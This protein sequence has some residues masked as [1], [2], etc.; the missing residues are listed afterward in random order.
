MIFMDH[1]QELRSALLRILI[2]LG[3]A[4]MFCYFFGEQLSE[5]L[6]KP[7]RTVMGEGG[8]IQGKIIYLSVLDK[9]LAHFQLAFWSSIILASPLWFYQVWRFIEPGLYPREK[10]VIA[11]FILVGFLLFA[12][13]VIF[14]Y[15]MALP[16]ALGALMNF[17]VTN[18]EAT[19][20][21]RGHLSLM[22]KVLVML[23]FLFQL[24]NILLVLGL[25]GLV[26]KQS[27][28]KWRGYVYFALAVLSA[29]LTPADIFT[30]LGLWVP[31]VALY[32]VGIGVVAL[33]VHP[34]LARKHTEGKES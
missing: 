17:G 32:E 8:A 27:L 6:L 22:V 26:T 1:L 18:V 33:L 14:G 2:I 3:A 11:P 19:I 13:G 23:G 9:V 7:L 4:F 10:K 5:I 34:Y 28:R 21:L 31:M 30:M 24:P 16:L 15:F 29:L 20:E 12:A 25:M